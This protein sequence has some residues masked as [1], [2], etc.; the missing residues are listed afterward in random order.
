MNKV[1]ASLCTVG[2]VSPELGEA[3][4]VS[5]LLRGSAVSGGL[6][7]ETSTMVS[8][9]LL[10][11]ASR[12]IE[13][14]FLFAST[15]RISS[16]CSMAGNGSIEKSTAPVI[17]ERGRKPRLARTLS[18]SFPRPSETSV[19]GAGPDGMLSYGTPT[20]EPEEELSP[21]SRVGE[22]KVRLNGD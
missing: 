4:I 22:R 5:S 7:L 20:V 21:R 6:S 14:F 9:E 12:D 11:G 8:L 19:R 1:V 15:S 18:M 3:D 13:S 17:T 16:A 10:R 2:A